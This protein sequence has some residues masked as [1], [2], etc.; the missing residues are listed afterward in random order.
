VKD[1]NSDLLAES[2]YILNTC[3]NYFSRFLN[4]RRI[5]DLT[6]TEI[7]MAEPLVADPSPFEVEIDTA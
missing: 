6:Q 3:N 5:S 7:H 1:D 2:H 4:V